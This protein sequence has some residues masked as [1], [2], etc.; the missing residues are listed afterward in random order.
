MYLFESHGHTYYKHSNKD[1]SR[2]KRFKNNSSTYIPPDVGK[3]AI[4]LH[5][6]YTLIPLVV[7]GVAGYY[8]FSE[9]FGV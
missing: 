3:V 7:I 2:D 4:C 8:L 6:K 9:K 1:G 5:A